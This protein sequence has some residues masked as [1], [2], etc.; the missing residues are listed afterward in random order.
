MKFLHGIVVCL[1]LLCCMISM[2]LGVAPIV[3]V[4]NDTEVL[5]KTYIVQYEPTLTS[6]IVLERIK[7]AGI[8]LTLRQDLETLMNSIS[9]K[10][11]R[12]DDVHECARLPKI[13]YIWPVVRIR[14]FF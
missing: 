11:E 9:V 12:D 13:R 4:S 5:E 7:D 1:L 3:Q 6:K 14:S 10:F 8:N 2:A